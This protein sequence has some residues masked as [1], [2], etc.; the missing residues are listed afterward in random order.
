MV[1]CLGEEA[2]PSSVPA[3]LHIPH[4]RRRVGRFMMTNCGGKRDCGGERTTE[5][6]TPY[7]GFSFPWRERRG[8]LQGGG[9][10]RPRR[11]Y[12]ASP[13]EPGNICGRC[14]T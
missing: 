1:A 5:P 2:T 4:N 6:L 12:Y 13:E 7:M 9:H 3:P 8:G 10:P 14:Y 11:R